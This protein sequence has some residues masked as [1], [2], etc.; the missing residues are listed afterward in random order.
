MAK[1]FGW[2]V[3]VSDPRY[4]FVRTSDR[5]LKNPALHPLTESAII[6]IANTILSTNSYSI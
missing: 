4:S 1:Q 2:S 6:R 5:S 3:V